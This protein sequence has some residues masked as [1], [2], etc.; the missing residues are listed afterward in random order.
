MKIEQMT[1]DK[2]TVYH[3]RDTF[4]NTVILRPDEAVLVLDFLYHNLDELTRQVIAQEHDTGKQE[5]PS[6]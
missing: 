1:T 6:G 4:G 5:R 3:I 2:L